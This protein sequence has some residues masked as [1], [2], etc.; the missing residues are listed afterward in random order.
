MYKVD[1]SKIYELVSMDVYE[2]IF[3]WSTSCVS[4]LD[5]LV[6]S[7]KKRLVSSSGRL[8]WT[9]VVFSLLSLTPNL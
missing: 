9:K 2:K 7:T 3:C 5:F 8:G 4:S 6:T 1:M